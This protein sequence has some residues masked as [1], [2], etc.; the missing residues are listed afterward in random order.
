MHSFRRLRVAWL[1]KEFNRA[2]GIFHPASV[3]QALL[4][5]FL[6]MAALAEAQDQ[7][8][9]HYSERDRKDSLL[10][11]AAPPRTLQSFLQ[12]GQFFGHARGYSM[13][14][15]NSAGLTDYHANAVGVVS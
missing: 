13:F 5:V 14:T 4:V 12:Q 6:G 11:T 9:V 1:H 2:V 8:F 3:Q 7:P 15:D 10:K